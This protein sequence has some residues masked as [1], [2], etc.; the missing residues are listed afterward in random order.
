[1]PTLNRALLVLYPISER[2][3]SELPK[4]LESR[5]A[6]VALPN[7]WCGILPHRFLA[8]SVARKARVC[9]GSGAFTKVLLSNWL[10]PIFSAEINIHCLC[11]ARAASV[12][13]T[14]PCRTL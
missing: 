6:S 13:R 3:A 12:N 9:E 2:V 4:N 5:P 10:H 14:F 11:L 8:K 7:W 1:M